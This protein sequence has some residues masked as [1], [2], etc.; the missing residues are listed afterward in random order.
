MNKRLFFIAIF[1]IIL[2]F[3]VVFNG[4]NLST[5]HP[6][7]NENPTLGDDVVL[8]EFFL[9]PPGPNYAF[10]WIEL[11]NP[12]KE[13]IKLY[14]F[15]FDTVRMLPQLSFLNIKL[16]MQRRFYKPNFPDYIMK[17]DTVE[18]SLS[19]IIFRDTLRLLEGFYM[20]FSDSIIFPFQF[21]IITNS[22]DAFDAHF[23]RG[24]FNPP[25]FELES[26]GDYIP[27]L[28][29]PDTTDYVF[30]PAFWN[31]LSVGNI[32]LQRTTVTFNEVRRRMVVIDIQ[33]SVVDFISYNNIPYWKSI[34]RYA[35]YYERKTNGAFYIADSPIPGWVS[36]RK[37]P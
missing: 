21:W 28:S 8:N 29:T 4:C 20:T 16:P 33:E 30:T 5:N 19:Y 26:V 24:P 6:P 31:P 15:G 7:V 11:Y 13:N 23:L 17:T 10:T 34:A 18:G 37:K 2:F 25:L 3:G 12:T 35:G 14:E 27:D 36:Q 9:V 32:V 22:K 1:I